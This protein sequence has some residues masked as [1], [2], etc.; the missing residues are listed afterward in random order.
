MNGLALYRRYIGVSFRGQMQYPAAFLMTT[1]GQFLVNITE[2]IGIWA[3]FRR[4]G[5]L[6]GWRL[7]E[8]AM[9]Y[10]TVSIAFSISDMLTRGFDVFG[11]QFVRTGAFD[12]ILLRPRSAVLQL[13][14]HEFRLSRLGRLAQGA[15]V[16]AYGAWTLPLH[17]TP[18]GA[19]VLA[20]AICGAVALF[21]GL[22]ILQAT[23]SFWTVESLEVAN[24]LTYGGVDAGQYPLDIYARWFRTF[25]TLVVPLGCVV[26]LPVA[27]VLGRVQQTGAPVWLPPVAPVAGLVFLAVSIVA[28]R[29]GMRHYASTGS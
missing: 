22:L 23:L 19:A 17:W 18:A 16:M 15:V 5:G 8:V 7:G 11:E 14:G 26:Y 27:F 3:L 24:T 13:M 9:F 2:F 10:G 28:W 20:F 21:I 6:H 29:F 1:A 25:L 4:F 12:R